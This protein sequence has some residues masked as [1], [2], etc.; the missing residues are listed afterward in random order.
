MQN[1]ESFDASRSDENSRLHDTEHKPNDENTVNAAGDFGEA[2]IKDIPAVVEVSTQTDL[3]EAFMDKMADMSLRGQC[4][5]ECHA[6]GAGEGCLSNV[7]FKQYVTRL[8]S[9]LNKFD[10]SCG[11]LTIGHGSMAG[12]NN[13]GW[14]VS[15][16]K[17]SKVFLF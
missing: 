11:S 7:Y 6:T 4:S 5:T 15:H 12:M 2:A 10:V 1:T 17:M 8:H 16:Q 9:I 13:K 14:P 3:K